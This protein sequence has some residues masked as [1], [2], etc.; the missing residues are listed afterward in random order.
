VIRRLMDYNPS[1]YDSNP[2]ILISQVDKRIKVMEKIDK[3]GMDER[4]RCNT[5]SGTA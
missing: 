4:E 2:W 5:S 1:D 3:E